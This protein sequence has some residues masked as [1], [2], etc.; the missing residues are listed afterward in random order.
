[1]GVG[2][3]TLEAGEGDELGLVVL[4]GSEVV[5]GGAVLALLGMVLVL[6]LVEEG[7]GCSVLVVVGTGLLPK[8]QVP[9]MT[10]W[11]SVPPKEWKSPLL[12][13]KS[14]EPQLSHYSHHEQQRVFL[15]G[16]RA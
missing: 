5:E 16:N 15:G 3:A 4:G 2:V 14:S 9:Y 12:K 11:E 1:M 13:S 6:V 7:F 8:D 10:P